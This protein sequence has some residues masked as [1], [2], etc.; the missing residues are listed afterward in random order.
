MEEFKTIDNYDNY[1][2]SNQGN[3]RNKNKNKFLKQTI[4]SDGYLTVTL[5]K[6]DEKKKFLVHRLVAI[7]FIP[8]IDNKKYI[9][10]ID[11]NRFNNNVDN[12]RWATTQENARNSKLSCKNKSSVK[13]VYF[14]KRDKRWCARIKID[15][16]TLH[17][18]SF[19]TIEEAKEARQLKANQVF[20]IF[21]N[22][23]EK[24]A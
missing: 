17:L 4:N 12:L 13:G 14:H 21:T 19:N 18:G 9:D 15:G 5:S 3:V 8:N 10:H 22:A 7:G 16:R 11:N 1:E 24:I 6:N 2:V 20:G 23:C